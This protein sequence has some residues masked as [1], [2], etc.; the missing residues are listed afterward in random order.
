MRVIA[1]L[2]LIFGFMAQGILDGQTFTHA[3]LGVVCGVTA[4]VCGLAAARRDPPHRWIGRIMAG[5]GFALGVWCVVMLPSSYRFQE[6]FNGRR[7]ERQKMERRDGTAN[8]SAA[9]NRR[10]AG[11]SDGS[12]NLFATV[13]ADRAFP[14]AVA[15]LGRCLH[16]T[17]TTI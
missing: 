16:R 17:P 15:E 9:A 7:E 12:D 6:K 2:A 3:V 1:L 4:L 11:Q 10:P 8:Q 13:A 5:L 14:A